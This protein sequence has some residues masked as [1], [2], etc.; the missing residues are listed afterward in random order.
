MT[1]RGFRR[2]DEPT[3]GLGA[4]G[5]PGFD[6]GHD[7]DD[8]QPRAE[9]PHRGGAGASE[10]SGA[11]PTT[12]IA[13]SSRC[14]PMWCS[15]PDPELRAPSRAKRMTEGVETD[16]ELSENALR[17]L[18]EEYKAIVRNVTGQTFR[19]TRTSSFWGDRGRVEVVDAQ[20][21]R[22]LPQGQR[23]IGHVRHGRQHRRHGVRQS[24]R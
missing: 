20:E 15:A 10:W 24:W 8:P 22:R 18:V 7:G 14:T 6:A 4:F 21:G 19:W 2:H 13:A 9:R 23:H 16:A 17:N 3:A 5:R 1:G 11:L 12:R